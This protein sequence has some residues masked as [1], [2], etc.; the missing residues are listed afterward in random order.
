MHSAHLRAS[1]WPF[2]YH[3]E[4]NQCELPARKASTRWSLATAEVGWE[5]RPLPKDGHT[6]MEGSGRLLGN[7]TLELAQSPGTVLLGA[8]I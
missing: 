8:C 7:L 4:K 3:Q 5:V 1:E 6:S 2:L